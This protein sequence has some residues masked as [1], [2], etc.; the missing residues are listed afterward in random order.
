MKTIRRKVWKKYENCEKPSEN[1]A[2]SWNIQVIKRVLLDAKLSI[3]TRQA[4]GLRSSA[5]VRSISETFCWRC[6][7]SLRNVRSYDVLGFHSHGGIP[8]WLVNHGKCHETGWFGSTP[9]SGT[10]KWPIR[11]GYPQNTTRFDLMRHQNYIMFHIMLKHFLTNYIWRY[12]FCHGVR[13][14]VRIET[15]TVT[16]G[17]LILRTHYKYMIWCWMKIAPPIPTEFEHL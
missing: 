10:S 2:K 11:R 1:S 17:C 3:S 7:T 13:T 12:P 16:W 4:R 8:K 5:N 9:I 14:W 6:L 15:T